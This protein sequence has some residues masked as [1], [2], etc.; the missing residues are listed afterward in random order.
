M[1]VNY[2]IYPHALYDFAKTTLLAPL[3]DWAK[4]FPWDFS[5]VVVRET[6]TW[7]DVLKADL[8]VPYF[9]NRFLRAKPA[10]KSDGSLVFVAPKNP[11]EFCLLF[12]QEQ[13]LEA[14]EFVEKSI[15]ALQ[16]VHPDRPVSALPI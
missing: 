6:A 3:T 13:W 9:N 16:S 1:A 5:K 2:S 14:E 10:S 11:V 12:D 15:A 8:S 4:G 7:Q